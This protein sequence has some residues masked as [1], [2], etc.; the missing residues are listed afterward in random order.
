MYIVYISV[1]YKSLVLQEESGFSAWEQNTEQII[2][3]QERRNSK[4]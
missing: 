2:C 1:K 4:I 3:K